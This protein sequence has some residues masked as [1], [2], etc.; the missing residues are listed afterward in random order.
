MATFYPERISKKLSGEFRV[1][2]K[3]KRDLEDIKAFV[4][5]SAT[6]YN[7]KL[8]RDENIT[9]KTR[10]EGDFIV[11]HPLYGVCVIEV[12]G[13][14]VSYDPSNSKWTYSSKNRETY[15]KKESPFSQADQVKYALNRHLKD[16]NIN[17]TK[18][19]SI[20]IFT[21][22]EK[23]QFPDS[24]EVPHKFI[25]DKNNMRTHD[26]SLLKFIEKVFFNENVQ[27]LK[28]PLDCALIANSI[29][30]RFAT[31]FS[32][33][34]KKEYSNGQ[35]R[36]ANLGSELRGEAERYYNSSS[37]NSLIS[38]AAGTGKTLLAKIIILE[39]IKNKEKV[40][41]LCKNKNLA[42]AIN[43]EIKNKL[44]DEDT[45]LF[46]SLNVD[47]TIKLKNDS[48]DLIIFD[49]AQDIAKSEYINKFKDLLK[50]FKE[51]NG[52]LFL[53]DFENQDI[54]S[55]TSL[56]EAQETLITNGIQFNQHTLSVNLRNN[57]PLGEYINDLSNSPVL[58]QN[59][60]L[61]VEM[62]FNSKE[63][64]V[65]DLEFKFSGNW[66]ERLSYAIKFMGKKEISLNEITVLCSSNE[67]IKQLMINPIQ[68]IEFKKVSDN[69]DS[70]LMKNNDKSSNNLYCETIHQFKGLEDHFVILLMDFV[71]TSKDSPKDYFSKLVYVAASRAHFG[72]S[73]LIS[74]QLG[75]LI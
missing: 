70:F 69:I 36:L 9:R 28:K 65:S 63:T 3:L 31:D 21:D 50:P 1:F 23:R 26:K 54:Y 68:G 41:Y 56:Q 2:E 67:S 58:W 74:K 66:I 10:L 17:N 25:F 24:T 20:V 53:G 22:I 72:A 38:G 59:F 62:S 7:T 64:A 13:G 15:T 57:K 19:I 44:D 12:K 61:D 11:I 4:L 60:Q 8:F 6:F 49:E 40:L 33:N 55:K 37:M 35:K 30:A 46:K 47:A 45:R 16:R 39:K 51:K 73:I 34:F 29:R 32:I 75:S 52:F 43:S 5:H 18:I 42:K 71:N 27:K 48:F 14:A